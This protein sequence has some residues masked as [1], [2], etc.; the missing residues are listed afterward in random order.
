MVAGAP[1]EVGLYVVQGVVHPPHVPLEVESQ[2]T[3]GGGI[4]DERPGRRLLGDHH[5]VGIV[6]AHGVVA[7][8]NEL[9]GD[10]VLLGPLLVKLLEPGIIDAKVEVEHRRDPIHA[11]AV[12]M[13]LAYPVEEVRYQE[14][15]DL[16][17][18]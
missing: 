10:E 17:A 18:P 13:V 16:R 15:A 8:P 11:H 3:V 5:D 9:D 1:R 4:G 6:L 14:G 2:A 12:G 7:L